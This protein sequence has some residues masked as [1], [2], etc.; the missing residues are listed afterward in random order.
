MLT[1]HD[2]LIKIAKRR[3]EAVSDISE[4]RGVQSMEDYRSRT[5]AI[6]TLDEVVT[7]IKEADSAKSEEKIK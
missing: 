4:G 2:L 7:M 6:R 5:A 1:T 3:A